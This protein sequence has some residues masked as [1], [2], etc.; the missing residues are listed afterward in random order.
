LYIAAAYLAAIPDLVFLV[1]YPS[2]TDP[3]AKVAQ[4]VDHT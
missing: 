3:E 1:D 2:T 4:L